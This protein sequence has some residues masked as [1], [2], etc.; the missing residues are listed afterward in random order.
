[1]IKKMFVP[2]A[3]LVLSKNLVLNGSRYSL[4]EGGFISAIKDTSAK[5]AGTRFIEQR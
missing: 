1:M 4:F 5:Y 3:P 2:D